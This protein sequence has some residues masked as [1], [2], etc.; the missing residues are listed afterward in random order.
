MDRSDIDCLVTGHNL[1]EIKNDPDI[2]ILL[3]G[4]EKKS[5]ILSAS[6]GIFHFIMPTLGNIIGN[7]YFQKLVIHSNIVVGIIFLLSIGDSIPIIISFSSPFQVFSSLYIFS[8]TFSF[9][10]IISNTSIY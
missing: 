10:V 6:V 1:N 5:I 2:V 4:S 7:S 3:F 9:V 8:I